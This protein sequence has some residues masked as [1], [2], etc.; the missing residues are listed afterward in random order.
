MKVGSRA[1]II[2]KGRKKMPK[3]DERTASIT[4]ATVVT[5]PVKHSKAG[6]VVRLSDF[7]AAQELAVKSQEKS[8]RP[9]ILQFD[10]PANGQFEQS[11]VVDVGLEFAV[12]HGEVLEAV[13][14][15]TEAKPKRTTK[16]SKAEEVADKIADMIAEKGTA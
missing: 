8:A 12:S 11:G 15:T 13:S 2:T 7:A 4:T 9:V 14:T 1:I 5:V 10:I 3:K 6:L 16:K